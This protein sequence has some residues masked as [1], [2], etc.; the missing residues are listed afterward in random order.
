MQY[1]ARTPSLDIVDKI[2]EIEFSLHGRLLKMC[3]EPV[4]VYVQCKATTSGSEIIS[5]HEEKIRGV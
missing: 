5:R 3:R 2:A 4:A 1:H